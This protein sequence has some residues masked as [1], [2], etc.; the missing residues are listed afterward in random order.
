[1]DTLPVHRRRR[2]C[3]VDLVVGF[4][5][6]ARPVTTSVVDV[7]AAVVVA[8]AVFLFSHHVSYNGK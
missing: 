7:A 1:V 6:K 3:R 2:S 8:V 4:V 5:G